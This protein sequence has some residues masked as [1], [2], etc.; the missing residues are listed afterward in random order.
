MVTFASPELKAQFIDALKQ[1][2]D[3]LSDADLFG[4]LTGDSD[5][6]SDERVLNLDS[7]LEDISWSYVDASPTAT[8]ADVLMWADVHRSGKLY[9]GLECRHGKETLFRVAPDN[10]KAHALAE[11]L[12]S[13]TVSISFDSTGAI[14]D[15]AKPAQSKE[16]FLGSF[17]LSHSADGT[18][19]SC[20]LLT[21]P[22]V[23]GIVAIRDLSFDKYTQPIHESDITIRISHDSDTPRDMV[24]AAA[25][26][27]LF[28]IN[29]SHQITLNFE[30]FLTDGEYHS[31][32]AE[33]QDAIDAFGEGSP[34]RLRPLPALHGV[35][36]L[37]AIHRKAATTSDTEFAI[38]NYVKT[39]EYVAA[40]VE[41]RA[42]HTAVRRWLVSPQALSP[43]ADFINKLVRT[44]DENNRGFRK[45][46]DALRMT[47]DECCVPD[48]LVP[49][50]PPFLKEL[51]NLRADSGPE[52]RQ[53]A[54]RKV[55]EAFVAT[56][57]ELSHAKPNYHR[58]GSECPATELDEFRRLAARISEQVVR[59]FLDLH[60]S[61]RITAP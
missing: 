22:T 35:S 48:L 30:P 60:P 21:G 18:E 36:E 46:A 43:S 42:M 40:T 32:G 23:L 44:V 39:V 26:A 19:M 33:V 24:R 9:D 49:D 5:S 27:Y 47:I 7:E 2:E 15:I 20:S 3:V 45:D 41:K 12:A 8:V 28:E 29:S 56:R 59:W 38:L 37:L 52:T 55:A 50:A 57:N 53:A 31:Y 16:E 25:E 34:P 14:S 58:T 13:N 54:L 61:H 4:L 51:R 17:S 6:D 11:Y 10:A 1:L